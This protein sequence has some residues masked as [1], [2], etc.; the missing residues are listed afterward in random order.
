MVFTQLYCNSPTPANPSRG[1]LQPVQLGAL[2]PGRRPVRG[3]TTVPW[4]SVII[5]G[6]ASPDGNVCVGVNGSL[7][8]GST[9]V[10]TPIGICGTSN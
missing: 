9:T 6:G 8:T 1:L 2:L 3:S 4:G 7:T 10:T 5:T